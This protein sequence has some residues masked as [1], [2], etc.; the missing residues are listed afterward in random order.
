MEPDGVDAV[1]GDDLAFPVAVFQPDL[2]EQLVSRSH[3]GELDVANLVENSTF[4]VDLDNVKAV[5]LANELDVLSIHYNFPRLTETLSWRDRPFGR[6]A[7][8]DIEVLANPVLDWQSELGRTCFPE[9][10]IA[11]RAA[12]D[13]RAVIVR[14]G[15]M[16]ELVMLADILGR[17]DRHDGSVETFETTKLSRRLVGALYNVEALDD[18]A[19]ETRLNRAGTRELVQRRPLTTV[20]LSGE[21]SIHLLV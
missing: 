19:G 21:F 6:I 18:L 9:F 3:E 11:V 15:E 14:Q 17:D 20:P 13:W 12:S 16:P 10:H 5:Q 8:S 7:W 4:P 1:L 2:A